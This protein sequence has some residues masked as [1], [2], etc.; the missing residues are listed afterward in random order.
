MADEYVLSHSSP[1]AALAE[2]GTSVPTVTR[3]QPAKTE[4]RNRS[5]P[6]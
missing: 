3:M 6:L 1:H 4:L 5:L 2:L